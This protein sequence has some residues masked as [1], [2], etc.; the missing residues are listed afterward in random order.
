M[1]KKMYIMGDVENGIISTMV[2]E[3]ENGKILRKRSS[4]TNVYANGGDQINCLT[5]EDTIENDNFLEFAKELKA[6]GF[7]FVG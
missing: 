6:R 7:V 5:F 1:T 2:L 4:I 3:V